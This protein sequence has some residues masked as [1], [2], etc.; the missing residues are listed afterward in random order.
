M[1]LSARLVGVS[2][3]E[4]LWSMY[5]VTWLSEVFDVDKCLN[6]FRDGFAL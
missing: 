4:G 6:A 3:R 5:F 1:W 2:P